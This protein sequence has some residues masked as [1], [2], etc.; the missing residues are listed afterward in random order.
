MVLTEVDLEIYDLNE[1]KISDLFLDASSFS[2]IN[3]LS[4]F[5]LQKV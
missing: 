4:S 3:W 5:R 1:F 2:L